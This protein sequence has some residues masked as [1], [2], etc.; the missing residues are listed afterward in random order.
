[1]KAGLL[2]PG[3][4]ILIL[5]LCFVSLKSTAK[6][7]YRHFKHY[8]NSRYKSSNYSMHTIKYF[9]GMK[10]KSIHFG[11][12]KATISDVD[13]LNVEKVAKIIIDNK[14]SVKVD[15][16][17]DHTGGYVY[18]W[19]LSKERADAVK[20]LLVSKGVDSSRVAATEF[21]Y[22]HP[23]A[24]N[25]TVKGRRMNRRVEIKFVG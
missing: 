4:L 18:N 25:K 12:A 13:I 17:A 9:A 2:K 10:I 21:G 23:I 20:A 7:H 5:A 15:G 24:T 1:M 8:K 22:T 16:Y 6:S 19:K 11:I 14:L 3:T